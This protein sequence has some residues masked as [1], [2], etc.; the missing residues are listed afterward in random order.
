MRLTFAALAASIVLA[1]CGVSRDGGAPPT[2]PPR[3]TSASTQSAG[4]SVHP[5]GWGRPAPLTVGAAPYAV[6]PTATMY[7]SIELG[8]IPARPFAAAGYTGGHWPTYPQ[9][10]RAYPQTHTVSIA[11]FPWERAACL[12]VEPGDAAPSQAPGWIRADQRAGYRKPCL[13]SDWWEWTQELAPALARARVALSSVY[14][15]VASYVGHPQLLPGFDAD[16]WTPR[17]L[18]R[19]LD[20]SLVLRSFLAI[21]QPPLA[22]RAALIARRETLRHVLIRYGCRRRVRER[23]HLGPRC[24]R[25]FAEGRAVDRALR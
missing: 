21:A 1:G 6:A 15:W 3:L 5:P 18:G 8:T 17:C 25:W 14:R 20:C 24:I 9:I 22:P 19:N 23:Q 2:P 16:Q 4:G 7:D 12:D 11:V 13:Y 10:R